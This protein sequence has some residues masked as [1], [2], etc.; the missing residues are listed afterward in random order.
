[1]KSKFQTTPTISSD[2]SNETSTIKTTLIG[3]DNESV[4]SK[5]NTTSII[6]SKTSVGTFND[7]IKYVINFTSATPNA[8]ITVTKDDVSYSTTSDSNGSG[9]ITVY[10]YGTWT[11]VDTVSGES[12]EIIFEKEKTTSFSGLSNT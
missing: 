3:N 5:F 10:D 8:T 11:L 4:K 6:K 9:S 1:M 2:F 7:N 12:K